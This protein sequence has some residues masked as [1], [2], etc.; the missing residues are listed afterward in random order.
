MTN[1]VVR[2]KKY[3][4]EV[5]SVQQLQKPFQKQYFSLLDFENVSFTL[6]LFCLIPTNTVYYL[7]G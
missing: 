4:K 5:F 7:P 3:R 2:V 6:L 1:L